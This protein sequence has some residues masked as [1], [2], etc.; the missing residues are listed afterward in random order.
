MG[1][2]VHARRVLCR[3]AHPHSAGEWSLS[4]TLVWF[5][6]IG[7]IQG[8]FGLFTMRSPPLFPTLL[9]MPSGW[10]PL[11]FGRIA[12]AVGIVLFRALREAPGR[13]RL[14]L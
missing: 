7:A 10:I 14:A 3:D 5:G 13:Q 2:R 1:H 12:S 4:A 11:Q 9:R 8:V 6:I